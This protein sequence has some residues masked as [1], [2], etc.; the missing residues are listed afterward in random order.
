MAT[1]RLGAPTLFKE[2]QNHVREAR[3]PL[4]WEAPGRLRF[5][6]ECQKEACSTA[7]WDRPWPAPLSAGLA[8]AATFMLNDSLQMINGA[9]ALLQRS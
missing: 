2:P 6:R 8:Q 9:A 1:L 4:R 3:R 5:L 7:A